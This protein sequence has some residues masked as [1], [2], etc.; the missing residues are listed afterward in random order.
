MSTKSYLHKGILG[1]IL[2][3]ISA[4]LP[5]AHI[6]NT[7]ITLFPIFNDSPL[8]PS[9]WDWHNISAFAITYGIIIILSAYFYFR[10]NYLA[11]FVAGIIL[12]IDSLF[13]LI[14]LWLTELNLPSASIPFS[15]SYGWLFILLGTTT[16]IFTGYKGWRMNM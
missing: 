1:C 2:L 11:V 16:I 3:C 13:V 7:Q 9:I 14:G 6:G 5:L 15:Y 8:P 12:A 10:K 4:V